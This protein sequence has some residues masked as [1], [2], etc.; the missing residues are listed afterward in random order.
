MVINLLRFECDR[1]EPLRLE[2]NSLQDMGKKVPVGLHIRNK[3]C[4]SLV[5]ES[6]QT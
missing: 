6:L 4:H 3:T 1:L 5:M 2:T